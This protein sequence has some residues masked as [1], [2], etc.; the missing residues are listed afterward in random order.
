M[1]VKEHTL[2]ELTREDL[3]Q[4]VA[5]LEEQ[6]AISRKWAKQ[7]GD[8][9]LSLQWQINRA[10]AYGCI[11]HHYLARIGEE[12]RKAHSQR[13]AELEE[14]VAS[15]TDSSD[16]WRKQYG[17]S[18][19]TIAALIERCRLLQ[20]GIDEHEA[21]RKAAETALAELKNTDA[22]LQK[23]DDLESELAYSHMLEAEYKKSHVELIAN[24]KSLKCSVAATKQWAANYKETL[25]ANRAQ[26]EQKLAEKQSE[27]E[28]LVDKYNELIEATK[29]LQASYKARES[30]LKQRDA[31]IQ[32]L[33]EQLEDYR[34]AAQWNY[35]A[36]QEQSSHVADLE[37]EL[38]ERLT[39]TEAAE[40]RGDIDRMAAV[41]DNYK[42]AV[43][44]LTSK[45]QELEAELAKQHTPIRQVAK[46]SPPMRHPDPQPAKQRAG[47]WLS[48]LFDNL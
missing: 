18:T 26:F 45:V 11:D 46:V 42:I 34:G 47:S 37:R 29:P 2:D 21:A 17:E 38:S 22:N 41:C 8:K 28:T 16:Y 30:E 40:L 14:K 48:K 15:L 35:D 5:A 32:K 20:E 43:T 9:N 31:R 33:L 19:E 39:P 4:K 23:I 13:E 3:V 12:A 10:Y 27:Y 44:S 24:I 7:C 1:P 6:L 36:Y 25:E